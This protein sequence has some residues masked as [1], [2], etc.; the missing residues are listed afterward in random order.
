M[1][2]G[3][4]QYL[5]WIVT[6]VG[7]FGFWL[8]GKK[9]WW[10]W[11][12]NIANQIFWAG[13]AIVTGYYIILV[14]VVF[15]SATFG[16]NAYL[17]TKEHLTH[18]RQQLNAL[19]TMTLDHEMQV[20]QAGKVDYDSLFVGEAFFDPPIGGG[21]YIWTGTTKIPADGRMVMR[22]DFPELFRVLKDSFGGDADGEQFRIPDLRGRVITPNE[23]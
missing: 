17:W 13:F 21:S 6:L 16:R 15:Y 14:G 3:V 9:I 20:H 22:E 8:G 10:S 7:C 12:V 19:N 5:S 18:K 11:Y 23:N 2:Y 1:N 4:D